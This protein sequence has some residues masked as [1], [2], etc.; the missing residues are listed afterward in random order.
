MGQKPRPLSDFPEVLASWDYSLNR[1]DL[2]PRSLSRLDDK[3]YPKGFW[4]LCSL[5][6]RYPMSITSRLKGSRCLVCSNKFVPGQNDLLSRFPGLEAYWPSNKSWS[7]RPRDIKVSMRNLTIELECSIHRAN[8]S[9]QVGSLARFLDNHES[10]CELC[11]IREKLKGKSIEETNYALAAIWDYARNPVTP[12]LVSAGSNV[13]YWWICVAGH[14]SWEASPYEI[15]NGWRMCPCCPGSHK[16]V[17]GCNDL[18]TTHPAIAQRWDFLRNSLAP[19]E[20]KIGVNKK[21]FFLCAQSPDHHPEMYLPNLKKNY[22]ACTF[23]WNEPVQCGIN[24]FGCLYPELVPYFDSKGGEFDA[25]RLRPGDERPFEWRCLNGEQHSFERTLATMTS[26]RSKRTCPVCMNRIIVPGLNSLKDL[27]PD[28][29][30]EWDWDLNQQF[31]SLSPE[32]VSPRSGYEVYWKCKAGHE[33]FRSSIWNRTVAETNCPSCSHFGFKKSEPALLYLVERLE[34]RNFR[35]ARKIGITNISSSRTRIRHWSYQ[36]F[37][38]VHS[39]CHPKGSLIQKL[40]KT[41]LNDWIRGEL[42]MCQYLSSDEILGGFTET[43]A[44][45]FPPN[46]EVI[47]MMNKKLDFLNQQER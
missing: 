10:P 4:W 16:L 43:F 11:R 17:Q 47:E 39:V 1:N 41:L 3:T 29:A 24:D 46:S 6:H 14:D 21:F 13:R 34:T 30:E 35:A 5:G 45:D 38:L 2:D 12:D 18:A 15:A 40:E 23:C 37:V 33:S 28:I 22:L 7:Q 25:H 32:N 8:F 44:P 9:I 19:N 20:V 36:G 26:S 42:G 31:E 27:A